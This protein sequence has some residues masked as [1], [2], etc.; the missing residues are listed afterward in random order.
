VWPQQAVRPSRWICPCRLHCAAEGWAREVIRL[1]QDAR[2]G[3]ALNVT[4]R[5]SVRW[6]ATDPNLAVALAEHHEMI[7]TEVLAVEF[8][9]VTGNGTDGGQVPH[10]SWHEHGDTERRFRFWLAV[11]HV[12]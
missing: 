1:I 5:I 12:P 8:E 9:P 3:D 4:D 6:T 11:A 10:G 7:A 2:K